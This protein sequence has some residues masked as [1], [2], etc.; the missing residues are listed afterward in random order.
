MI[1]SLIWT[2][3]DK[4]N[5]DGTAE[6]QILFKEPTIKKSDGL[7]CSE[8]ILWLSFGCHS[9]REVLDIPAFMAITHF[10]I[11]VSS[12]GNLMIIYKLSE[13]HNLSN[14]TLPVKCDASL[15]TCRCTVVYTI[16]CT[17]SLRHDVLILKIERNKVKAIW[18]IKYKK[19][20]MLWIYLCNS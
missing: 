6:W 9:E 2:G 17:T 8:H 5:I 19:S 4:L 12:L 7:K 11:I 1:R 20:D 14:T 18:G 15:S 13:C 10:F 3:V 16:K